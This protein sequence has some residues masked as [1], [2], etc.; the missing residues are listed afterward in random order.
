MRVSDGGYFGVGWEEDGRVFLDN[1]CC[2]LSGGALS[3]GCSVLMFESGGK[4]TI[5]PV[6]VY[7]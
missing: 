7:Y 4:R 3:P 5:T 1:Y 2:C 6:Y